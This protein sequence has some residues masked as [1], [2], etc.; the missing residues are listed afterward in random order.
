MLS[1]SLNICSFE[2]AKE[3]QSWPRHTCQSYQAALAGITLPWGFSA[4]RGKDCALRRN[5]GAGIA[6]VITA[7]SGASAGCWAG[8]PQ[9]AALAG[10]SSRVILGCI[11]PR[12]PKEGSQHTSGAVPQS[13]KCSLP[14]CSASGPLSMEDKGKS[15]ELQSPSSPGPSP[16]GPG[17]AWT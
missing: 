8:F 4:Q 3:D 13:Y 14:P 15:W 2:S 11:Q 12:C 16:C 10:P 1:N 17:S 7:A 6:G 5:R 9:A